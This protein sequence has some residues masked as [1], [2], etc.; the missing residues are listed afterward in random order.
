M[1]RFVIGVAALL[2]AACIL[3]PTTGQAQPVVDAPAGLIRGEAVDGVSI[4]RGVPYALPPTGWRR[5]RPPAQ[6]PRWSETREATRF[7]PACHQ[8]VARGTSIYAAA[9]PPTM[10]EDCLSLNIW[11]PE[12]AGE[13]PV[14]VWIHGGALTTGAGS[15]AMYDGARM[16]ASQG[17]VVVSINY[18][19]GVLGYLA[20]PEL[21]AESRQDTSGNYGLLDQIAALRWVEA[22]IAAF[23]GDPDNVTIA[24]ESAGALSVM[25]LMASPQA[26]GL[27]DR[28]IAQSAY[29]ISTPELRSRRYGDHPAET[30]GIWLQAQLGLTNLADLR[31]MDAQDLTTRSLAAGYAPW[32]T[33]DGQILPEQLV[34]IFDRGQQAPVPLL[35]GFNEGEIRSLR[36][37]AAPPPADAAAYEEAIRSRYGDLADAFLAL[38]PSSDI[39]ASVLATPRDALYGWTAERLARRQ[40]ALGQPAFLYFFNH[41]YPT[42]DEAD[43]HAFHAAEIPYVFGTAD[44]APPRWPAVPDT[45]VER[46]LSAAMMSYWASF[47]RAG[48][49]TAAGQP[50]WPAYGRVRAYMAFEQGPVVRA[51]LM[52][53]MFELREAVVC[54]RRVAGSIPWNWNFGVL[55]P[56][57]PPASPACR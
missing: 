52:P 32:G 10:G 40:T 4:F 7:G 48:A 41:G 11:A 28:A 36:F 27:F 50:D 6:M 55:S 49:P 53:G 37:L 47:A 51:R 3:S 19:L 14:L 17:I 5:W 42:A 57:L 34:E 45:P 38:Y 46:G 21:S 22:N 30:V 13:A 54:R 43:L 18:R 8:P 24:G 2:A 25:Y 33:I 39:A 12:G 31:A 20:H 26:R 44:R 15:E 16:A 9:E 23:G 29:M 1:K 56:S 35:A